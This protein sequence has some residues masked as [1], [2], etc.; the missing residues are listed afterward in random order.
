MPFV[1]GV[2]AS[3]PPRKTAVIEIS[4]SRGSSRTSRRSPF[5]SSIRWISCATIALVASAGAHGRAFRVERDDREIFVGQ[6]ARRDPLKIVP[7]DFLHGR[8]VVAGEVEVPGQ[9]PIRAKI[10]RLAAHRGQGRQMMAERD[11]LGLRQFLRSHSVL[12]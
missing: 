8:E 6:I 12:L 5:E 7:R 4:G 2:S 1:A 9:K 10:G 11:L 3:R